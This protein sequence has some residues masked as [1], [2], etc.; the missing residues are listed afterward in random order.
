MMTEDDMK[1]ELAFACRALFDQGCM[2]G[3]GGHVSV[4]SR[5]PEVYLVNRLDR[6]FSETTPDDIVTTAFD[7]TSLAG[8]KIP[9]PGSRFHPEIYERRPDVHAIVHTHAS[10]IARFGVLGRPLRLT[11]LDAGF[12]HGKVAAVDGPFGSVADAAEQQGVTAVIMP[13]HGAVT[14]GPD[15]GIAVVYH[16]LLNRAARTDLILGERPVREMTADE[17]AWQI[18]GITKGHY[19]DHMWALMRRKGMRSLGLSVDDSDE[20]RNSADLVS[21]EA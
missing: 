19:F 17:V 9:P 2:E 14:V 3:I 8:P 11:S 5:Q 12:L 1:N 18:A 13:H 16:I 6:E 4:R 21:A 7:G 10:W 20:A 15:L